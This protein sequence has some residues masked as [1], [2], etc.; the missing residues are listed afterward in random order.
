MLPSWLP[1]IRLV[2]EFF[3]YPST[4]TGFDVCSAWVFRLCLPLFLLSSPRTSVGADFSPGDAWVPVLELH[5]NYTKITGLGL[6]PV[7]RT[8]L[9]WPLHCCLFVLFCLGSPRD[10]SKFKFLVS[11][12]CMSCQSFVIIIFGRPLSRHLASSSSSVLFRTSTSWSLIPRV[13]P[14]CRVG[15]LSSNSPC[16]FCAMCF[17]FL[18]QLFPLRQILLRFLSTSLWAWRG[19]TYHGNSVRPLLR[20]A[21]AIGFS[22]FR[23]NLCFAI[24]HFSLS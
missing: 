18:L 15:F 23:T 6:R 12:L 7:P 8:F 1:H 21:A 17:S 9:S 14:L 20:R 3:Q 13:R 4:F 5:L 11:L 24:F 19:P 16:H 2:P 10:P 22:C